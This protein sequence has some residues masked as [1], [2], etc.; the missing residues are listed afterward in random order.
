MPDKV[1]AQTQYG[2]VAGHPSNGAILF[3][4][5]PY[6]DRIDG[7]GRLLPPRPPKAWTTPPTSPDMACRVPQIL[8]DSEQDM[9]EYHQ[10]L[11]GPF[12]HAPVS[13]SG[14]YL[15]LW[16]PSLDA[17]K[18]R[19]VMVWL[20]GGGFAVGGPTRPREDG[21]RLATKG[22]VVV[23][24]PAH[25][26]GANGY[27]YLDR[28]TDGR[29]KTA[30]LG[31]L[32]IVHALRWIRDNIAAFGGDPDHV[33]VFGESGGGMKVSTLL[34]MPSAKGLVHRAICQGGIFASGGRMRTLSA[35]DAGALTRTLLDG[36]GIADRPEAICQ[37]SLE[38]FVAAQQELGGGIM[39]WR[40]VVDG[41]VLPVAPEDAAALGG[42]LDIPVLIGTAAHESDFFIGGKLNFGS[43]E[44]LRTVL[45]DLAE[46]L[47]DGYAATPPSRSDA[48]I[49]QA[50]MTDSM[51]RIPSVRGAEARV[52][53]TSPVFMYRVDWQRP[54]NAH[55]RASHGAEVPFVFDTLDVPGYTRGAKEAEIV[56][57]QMQDSWLAFARTGN[58]NHPGIPELPPYDLATRSTIVFDTTP[59]IEQDPGGADRSVWD[60]V[61]PSGHSAGAS[62]H[63]I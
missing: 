33:T 23:V 25:R 24:S 48:A 50:I 38:E 55:V 14:L 59:R 7:E 30:N 19:P 22:D 28:I 60:R 15:N 44:T 36:L 62:P 49:Y 54:D 2:P 57:R 51:F 34:A 9:P 12:H 61:S 21:S 5:I 52:G 6:A 13:E 47:F 63:Q 31:M 17:G 3:G 53:Q 42:A 16:T 18:T 58:P 26:L 10:F 40:P 41:E 43:K 29:I 8:D 4:G 32:D 20:H 1:I 45:G 35:D 27:L 46:P 39:A 56:M 37:L 11:F